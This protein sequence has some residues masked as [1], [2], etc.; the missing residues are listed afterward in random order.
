MPQA[1]PLLASFRCKTWR[2]HPY[3]R[4][5]RIGCVPYGASQQELATTA[6]SKNSLF[7][8]ILAPILESYR[9]CLVIVGA[10]VLHAGLVMLDLP[11]W[12]CPMRAYLGIPCPGC[13]LSR[14]ISALLRGDWETSFA[15]HAFAPFF[16]LALIL[17]TGVILLPPAQRHRL[18]SYIARIERYTGITAILLL[19]LVFYWLIR[20]LFFR[21]AFMQLVMR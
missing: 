20:M 21:E 15:L 10:A 2:G 17:M 18:I 12:P 3:A 13:G 11:G 1:K 5:E 6:P 7:N 19:G 8:P 16:V 14:A 9:T 4:Y